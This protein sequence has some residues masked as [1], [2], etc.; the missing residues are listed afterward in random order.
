MQLQ[1]LKK[2]VEAMRLETTRISGDSEG[3]LT[4]GCPFAPKKHKGGIDRH[5]SFGISYGPNKHSGYLCFTCGSKGLLV[6][7]VDR[8]YAQGLYNDFAEA[9]RLAGLI[10]EAEAKVEVDPVI[11]K[12]QLFK[13]EEFENFYTYINYFDGVEAS[14]D[15]MVYLKHRGISEGAARLMDLRYSPFSRR[16]VFPIRLTKTLALG[17]AQ[18]LAL[19]PTQQLLLERECQRRG[20]SVPPKVINSEDLKRDFALMGQEFIACRGNIVLVEG[21]FAYARLLTLKL[22]HNLNFFPVATLG[23]KVSDGQLDRLSQLALSV[24]ILFDDDV[25]GQEATR[26]IYNVLTKKGVVVNR[27]N[28]SVLDVKDVDDFELEHLEKLGILKDPLSDVATLRLLTLF[29]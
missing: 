24:Y 23:T 10:R 3:W 25:S 7:L 22:A 19:M 1:T 15:A 8:L 18:R 17:F 2:I 16:I 5:P 14:D 12:T 29:S 13:N 21:L 9:T 6:N 28:W 27:V 11:R 4:T 20:R 26:H